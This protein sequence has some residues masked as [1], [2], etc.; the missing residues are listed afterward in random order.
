MNEYFV[1]RLSYQGL[2][3][4]FSKSSMKIIKQLLIKQVFYVAII[5]PE[6]ANSAQKTN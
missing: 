5:K 3:D 4:D 6:L 2:I 1:P